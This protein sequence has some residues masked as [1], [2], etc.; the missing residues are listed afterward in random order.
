MTEAK[1]SLTLPDG[2]L[3]H[4]ESTDGDKTAIM[5]PQP[6]PPGSTVR[7]RLEGVA[8]EF[9]LKVRNCRKVGDLF[10]I[11]GRVRNATREM[12]AALVPPA[13]ENSVD[14]E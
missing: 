13:P 5:S 14:K 8:C 11:D 9:Q 2:R 12:K 7:A 10:L 1:L 3:A 4:I 6:S